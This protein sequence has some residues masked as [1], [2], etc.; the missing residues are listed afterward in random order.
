MNKK[1]CFSGFCA[2]VGTALALMPFSGDAMAKSIAR[3]NV[4]IRAQPSLNAAIVFTAPLG[5]PI[6]IEKEVDKWALFKD[7]QDR[8]GWVYKPLISDKKTA[9]IEVEKANIRSSA[10]TSSRVV[11]TGTM[12]EIYEILTLQGEW[13][14]L[15]YYHG[16]AAVGWVRS[17]LVFGE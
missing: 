4:N 10:T 17:D 14:R 11:A 6:K 12:G 15:G 16:G 7:W 1:A 2:C 3:D 8:S 5:Y 9:V 13:V